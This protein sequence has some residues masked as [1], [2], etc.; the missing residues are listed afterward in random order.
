MFRLIYFEISEHPQL[1]NIKLSFI[2]DKKKGFSEQPFT[3]VIIGPNGTGKSYILRTITEVMRN[4]RES[5][6]N[7]EQS[8]IV[9]FNFH[10]RYQLDNNTFEIVSKNLIVLSKSGPKRNYICF[11]NRPWDVPIIEKGHLFENKTG[12]EISL[13]EL[14][15]P[16][17]LIASSVMLNDRFI[18]SESKPDEF[19]QYLGVRRT[20]S[21]TSTQTFSK[22]TIR[23]LFDAKRSENFIQDFS[24]MLEFMEFEKYFRIFYNTKYNSLFF[25]GNLTTEEFHSFFKEW[26][27]SGITKRKQDNPLW[28]LWYYKKLIKEDPSRLDKVVEYLNQTVNNKTIVLDKPHSKSKR[29]EIDLFNLSFSSREYD[30]I[31]DLIKLDILNL[32]NISIKKKGKEFLIEQCSSGEYHLLISLLGLYSKIEENSLIVIDEPEISLHPNWQMKYIN[33]LK[34]MFRKFNGCHFI[35]ATHSHF[36]LSDLEPKSSAVIRLT[37]NLDTY[38]IDSELLL[39]T[40]TYGW[41]TEEILYI[42]FKVRTTRNL[43]LENDLRELLHKIAIKSEDHDRMRTILN[44]IRPLSLS[45]VDPL[46]TIINKA[47]EYLNK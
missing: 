16:D 41:S 24:E 34:K 28:G 36:L 26:W 7:Y 12:F 38:K 30:F 22:K 10:L 21:L 45:E 8:N 42:V 5:R 23:Y 19:Y 37:R 47:E 11:K 14:E 25:K 29:V 33:F 43:Y 35:I 20:R 1:G 2:E 27:N 40:E 39:G 9:P 31:E 17:K 6:D 15:F 46:N 3:T 18:F 13:A 44:K 4:F 32:D